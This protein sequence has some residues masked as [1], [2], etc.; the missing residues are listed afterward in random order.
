MRPLVT[1]TAIPVLAM[2][3][4]PLVVVPAFPARAQVGLGV[5]ITN[6]PPVLPVYVQPPLPAPGYLWTP[7]F[8]S[9]AAESGYYWVP[10]TWVQPP[11]VGLLWTPG[12]WGFNNGV[13]VFNR[14]YWGPHVGFYGGINYGFGYTG[15]GFLGGEWRGR[16]FAYN[17]AVNN[18]GGVHV[19]N[20]YDRT[21]INNTTVNRISFNGPNGLA[22]RPTAEETA[23]AREQHVQATSLQEQHER[24][25]AQIPGLRASVNHGTPVVAATARPAEFRGPGVVPARPA[26]ARPAESAR[27]NGPLRPSAAANPALVPHGAAARPMGAAMT[28]RQPSRV[29]SPVPHGPAMPAQ[30]FNVTRPVAAP[31]AAPAAHA[32]VAPRAGGAGERHR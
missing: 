1:L 17:R 10:G 21:V 31:R 7:G 11:A 25:A 24:Q 30:R 2:L 19:T 18:F 22:A 26:L 8:W 9:Y 23:F 3:T 14:G 29:A 4:A 13:Y 28:P 5:S 6:A 32:A 20:V 12:Y 15:V 27:V 16:D